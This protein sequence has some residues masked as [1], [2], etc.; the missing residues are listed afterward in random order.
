MKPCKEYIKPVKEDI[1]LIVHEQVLIVERQRQKIN[2]AC[3]EHMLGDDYKN[4]ADQDYNRDPI[5]LQVFAK[6]AIHGLIG[7]VFH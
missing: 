2:E 1:A 3:V 6:Y 5:C 4:H 7:L